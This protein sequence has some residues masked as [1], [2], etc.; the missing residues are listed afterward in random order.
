MFPTARTHYRG[1]SP[2]EPAEGPGSE[3]AASTTKESFVQ[4]EP[5]RQEARGPEVQENTAPLTV[6]VQQLGQRRQLT[7]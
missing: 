1:P 5:K 2:P 7:E 6:P 4:D 3:A